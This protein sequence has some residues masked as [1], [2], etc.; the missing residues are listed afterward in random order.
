VDGNGPNSLHV[1]FQHT[2]DCDPRALSNVGLGLPYTQNDQ[3][4]WSRAKHLPIVQVRS[5]HG[6]FLGCREQLC[7]KAVISRGFGVPLPIAQ[8]TVLTRVIQP[9]AL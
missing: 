5:H 1:N 8:D 4:H 6:D 9:V 7:E 3:N 2:C